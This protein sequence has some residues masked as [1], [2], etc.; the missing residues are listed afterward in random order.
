MRLPIG[1][2]TPA[3]SESIGR[4][5]RCQPL[6]GLLHSAELGR[7][8]SALLDVELPVAGV[9]AEI[10]RSEL[11]EIGSITREG[12]GSLNPEAGELDVTAGWGHGGN[13][14]AVMPGKGKLIDRDYTAKE[15]ESIAA[16]AARSP[17]E[18]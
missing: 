12:G 13:G 15:R 14:S 16:G 4:G 3:H 5:F 18:K 10:T 17:S 1:A 9:T 11:R 6:R 7:E 8:L 2:R